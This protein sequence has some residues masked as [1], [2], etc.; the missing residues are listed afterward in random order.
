[1]N[2]NNITENVVQA[3]IER[4]DE[5]AI[6]EKVFNLYADDIEKLLTESIVEKI[7]DEITI[8]IDNG[9]YELPF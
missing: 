7:Y 4:M 2:I 6:A 8:Q 3:V 5:D 1:M 9:E